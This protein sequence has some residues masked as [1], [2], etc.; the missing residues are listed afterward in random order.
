MKTASLH[1]SR[2]DL[3]KPKKPVIRY[4]AYDG[5]A[6]KGIAFNMIREGKRHPLTD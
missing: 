6:G 3:R 2:I 5:V 4:K 1:D